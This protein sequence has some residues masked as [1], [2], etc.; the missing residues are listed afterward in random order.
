MTLVLESVRWTDLSITDV[1]N[2]LTA[3]AY[4]AKQSVNFGSCPGGK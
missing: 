2:K 3:A 4:P 1:T